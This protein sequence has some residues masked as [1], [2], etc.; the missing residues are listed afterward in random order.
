MKIKAVNP[1]VKSISVQIDGKEISGKTYSLENG[2]SVKLS[3]LATPKKAVKTIAYKSENI[4]VAA[5]SRNGMVTS[6]TPG[7]T[8]ITVT[9]TNTSASVVADNMG[10]YGTTEDIARII[11]QKV[12]GDLHRIQTKVLYPDDFNEV[13]DRNH[14]EM[15]NGVL[16]E[17]VQSN[18]DISGYDTVFIGYPVWLAYHNLIQCTQA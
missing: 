13:V 6:K 17:L 5:V 15:Q 8:R 12:G 16:P 2:K 4:Q 7:K 14:Q 10:Q 9:V 18:L 11:Q 3:I 1:T